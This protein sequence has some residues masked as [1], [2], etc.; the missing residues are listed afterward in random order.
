MLNIDSNVITQCKFTGKDVNGNTCTNK[1]I[2]DIIVN[3]THVWT[4]PSNF[5][6]AS[7]HSAQNSSGTYYVRLDFTNNSSQSIKFGAKIISANAYEYTT[8]SPGSTGSLIAKVGSIFSQT[9]G[10]SISWTIS[11]LDTTLKCSSTYNGS[12]ISQV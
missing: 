12:M 4:A 9:V 7:K 11:Y 10:T 2:T 8:I 6:I 5:V 3:G 1:N